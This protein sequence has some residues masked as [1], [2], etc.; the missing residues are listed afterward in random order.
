MSRHTCPVD[1]GSAGGV[2]LGI[3][4]GMSGGGGGGG[5]VITDGG[6]V[7]ESKFIWLIVTISFSC[8]KKHWADITK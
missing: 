5:G 3:L 8:V 6:V 2:T 1:V 4:G 7:L